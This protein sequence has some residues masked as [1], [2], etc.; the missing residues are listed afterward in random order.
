MI[1]YLKIHIDSSFIVVIYNGNLTP[2]LSQDPKTPPSP[3]G[4]INI[5][6]L[7][8]LSSLR[9]REGREVGIG[10]FLL[11]L[12]NIFFVNVYLLII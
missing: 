10:T 8:E 9:V 2:N 3:Q 4:K 11:S 6:E 7:G 5:K 1:N 12:I